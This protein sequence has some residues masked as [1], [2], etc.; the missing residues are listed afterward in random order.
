MKALVAA[1][2]V[3]LAAWCSLGTLGLA[4]SGSAASRVAL[5]PPW[6]LL[7]ALV[8]SAFALIRATRLSPSQ[9]SPLFGTSVVIVPWLPIPLPPAALLWTGPFAAAIWTI[10]IIGVLGAD[11]RGPHGRWLTDAHRAPLAAAAVALALYGASAWWLAPVLPDGD[12]PHYLILAQSLVRDGDLRIEN[13]HQR[14]D[15]LEYS[16]HADRPHYLRRGVNGAIYSI[17]APGLPVLI[18]PAFF[19]FGYAG[20]VVFLAL[21]GAAGTALVWHLGYRT[22]QSAGAAWFGWASCAVTTPF[23]FQATQ[24]FPDGTAATCVLLG[25]LPVMAAGFDD[26]ADGSTLG[27]GAREVAGRTAPDVHH[28]LLGRSDILWLVSG[29]SLAI[30][31]WLQTRLALI[32]AAAALCVCARMRRITELVLFAAV[33]LVSAAAWFGYFFVLY[34]TLSPAAPYGTYTQTTLG[35]LVRGGPGLVFDQQFGLVPHAPVYGFILAGVI[36]GAI[37]LRRWNWE[38]LIVMVPY[39]IG[40]GMFQIWW[41]G[42]SAPARL[43]APIALVLGVAA[44]RIWHDARTAATRATGLAAL[45]TS[46]L[47]TAALALPDRGSLL[48]NFRDGVALW[49]EWGNDL[50]DVPRGLPSLFRD[51]PSQAWLKAGIWCGSAAASWLAIRAAWKPDRSN[52]TGPPALAWTTIW[53]LAASIMVALTLAWRVGGDQPLTPETGKL[54]LLRGAAPSR[55]VAYDYGAVRFESSLAALSRLRVQMDRLRRPVSPALL[56][57]LTDVPAG[58]YQIHALSSG[59]AEGSLVLRVGD[60]S[61]PSWTAM[62]S[63]AESDAIGT[64]LR[65]PVSVRSLSVE[66]DEAARRTVTAVEIEP[67][68][69]LRV[70]TRSLLT[71]SG[72]AHRAAPYGSAHVYFMD[73]HAYPEPSGFWVAGGREARLVVAQPGG[74]LEL[75]LRNAPVENSVTIDVDGHRREISMHPGEEATIGFPRADPAVDAI[76]RV[77]TSSGFR[78]SRADPAN[79]DLRHLGCW[80]EIR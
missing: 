65:L 39:V 58:T 41:G 78:P 55:P 30:L 32:A 57:S 18:A 56:L 29:V 11:E 38:L 42:T 26:R 77:R 8:L 59:P 60:T 47:V 17:H 1:G 46:V 73:D 20:A 19:L 68:D 25:T 62:L 74:R 9:L 28:G 33:P 61:L 49:L 76:V 2:C 35:N 16:L 10:V 70:L 7:P 50:I 44:A 27:G 21:V 71:S 23:F 5:L 67:Q 15:Y 64:P 34:G 24:V 43:L 22:T 37:R 12:S 6:W 3:G 48:L 79:E 52:R 36:V 69:L 4:G 80:V 14:G 75:L 66:G 53:C 63:G 72:R 45:G 54:G 31:P 51:T 13:N 40:V